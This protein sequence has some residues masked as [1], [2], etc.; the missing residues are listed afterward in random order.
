MNAIFRSAVAVA[1][2]TL[3]TQ[4]A[5]EVV[6]YESEGFQGRSFTAE[7]A[8]PNLERSGFSDRASSVVVVGAAWEVCDDARFRGRCMV[9]RPGRYAS[10]ASMALND[11]V[12]SMRPVSAT[13]RI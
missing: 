3:S 4:A 2:L 7:K 12:V 11:R 5:A 8:V 1:A 6:F 13:A 10:P 9:L